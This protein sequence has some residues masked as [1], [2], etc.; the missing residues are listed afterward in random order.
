[1]GNWE[2]IAFVVEDGAIRSL[3]L[4]FK[5]LPMALKPWREGLLIREMGL[6]GWPERHSQP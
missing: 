6:I 2:P 1:M 5:R 3:V 4:N